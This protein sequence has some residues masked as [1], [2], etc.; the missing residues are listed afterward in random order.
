MDGRYERELVLIFQPA[1]AKRVLVDSSR[2]PLGNPSMSK[3]VG[4][5]TIEPDTRDPGPSSPI[6]HVP[7]A[8]ASHLRRFWQILCF[9]RTP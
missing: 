1:L 3:G 8:R 7:S 6:F 9:D 5:D 4:T 2:L